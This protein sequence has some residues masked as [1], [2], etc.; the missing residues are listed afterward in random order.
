MMLDYYSF[1][2][3]EQFAKNTF[4]PIVSEILTFFN[5]HWKRGEDGNLKKI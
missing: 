5:E 2:Q 3:D 4:V 1:T